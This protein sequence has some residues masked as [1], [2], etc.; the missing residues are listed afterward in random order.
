MTTAPV[1]VF[2]IDGADFDIVEELL[3]AG[4]MPTIAGLR[5]AGA[6]GP[7]RSTEPPITPVAWSTFLTGLR[8]AEH[9]IFNFSTNPFRG[10]F[11]IESAAHRAG[12]PVWR[13]LNAA[14]LRSAMVLIPFTHPV[15]DVGG[16]VVSGYGGPERPT[17]HPPE[18]AA[19]I[20]ERFPNLVTAHHPMKERYWEDYDRSRGLLVENVVEVERLC[21]HVLASE[22]PDLFCVDFMSSDTIGHLAWHLRDPQHPAHDPALAA[23]HIGE[24][25]D[26]VDAAVGRLIARA[27]QIYGRSVNA[28]VV[29]DHGMK[30]IH[31]VF[32]VNRWLEQRGH[33]RFRRRSA[34]RVRGLARLDS[35]MALRYRWYP[36]LYDRLVPF[37]AAPATAN[38]TMRDLDRWHTD[39]YAY[40]TGGPIYLG[41]ATGRR[42]DTAFRDRLIDELR[43]E[44]SPVDGQPAFTVLAGDDV[45]HGRFSDKAPDILI[46]ANDPRI[47][48]DSSRRAWPSAWVRHEHLDPSQNYGYSGHHG[49]IGIIAAAGPSVAH[50][51]IEGAGIVDLA[52]TMLALLGVEAETELDGRPLAAFS[53]ALDPVGT[54]ASAGAVADQTVYSSDEERAISERL[55]ALGYE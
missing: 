25:Y 14:G 35:H 15:E 53:P 23:D 7:L 5:A 41:E 44:P 11:R 6:Y 21:E 17:I 24:V 10:G 12:A 28:I 45:H 4:R 47:M 22:R 20:A 13:Y 26:A 27:E 1:L 3:A 32:H 37:G 51:R 46:T 18:A 38:R 31:H 30:P 19:R 50:E 43:R 9:G 49:P 33:L 52:P 34:Q 29:S 8:P 55:E 42:G 39:A 36:G 16:L 54:T 2:G 48:V 40:G